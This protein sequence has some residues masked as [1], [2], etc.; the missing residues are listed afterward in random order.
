MSKWDEK[1]KKSESNSVGMNI[2]KKVGEGEKDESVRAVIFGKA[3]SGKTH[4]ALTAPEPIYVIDTELGT[5]D[6]VNKV[7]SPFAEKDI[8]IADVIVT[9]EKEKVINGELKIVKDVDFIKSLGLIE[10]TVEV[11]CSYAMNNPEPR[12]TIVIDTVSEVWSW[13]EFWLKEEAA[14]AFTKSGEMMQTEWYKA[15]K[16]Y[17]KMMFQLM[18]CGWNVVLTSKVREIYDSR[19]RPTG[20]LEAR[21]QKDTPHWMRVYIEVQNAGDHREFFTV[22]NRFRDGQKMFIDADFEMIRKYC[23]GEI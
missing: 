8:N 16:K 20:V 22:K 21:M 6:L 18:K 7:D 9:V 10:E 2:F 1:V 13:Y 3:G 12:G 11:I 15:N 4:F 5:E 17:T 19:G 14:S 23:T